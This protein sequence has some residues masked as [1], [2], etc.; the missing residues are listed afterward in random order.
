M[1]LNWEIDG[2]FIT[3]KGGLDKFCKDRGLSFA[4][5]DANLQ[6]CLC[7]IDERSFSSFGYPVRDSSYC[8]ICFLKDPRDIKGFHE[9]D[10]QDL[11]GYF[12]FLIARG[13][14]KKPLSDFSTEELQTELDR[15]A[16]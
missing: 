3:D 10:P 2:E 8:S 1:C 9:Y 5:G 13:H 12:K 6:S 11:L 7:D 15:R 14:F 16:E 4:L